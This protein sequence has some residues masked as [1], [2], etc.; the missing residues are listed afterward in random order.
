LAC[1][2]SSP[3]VVYRLAF[4]PYA[5]SSRNSVQ[6]TV[7]F[8]RSSCEREQPEKSVR[9]AIRLPPSK[10]EGGQ[11]A[12][13]ATSATPV[14]HQP[15]AKK[16]RRPSGSRGKR[17]LL[18]KTLSPSLSSVRPSETGTASSARARLRAPSQRRT[19]GQTRRF[20]SVSASSVSAHSC[21]PLPRI[22]LSVV[23]RKLV[24]MTT[25]PKLY[26]PDSPQ[27]GSHLGRDKLAALTTW[28][29]QKHK[30][31]PPR[32]ELIRSTVDH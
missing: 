8:Q 21:C 19:A 27:Q 2:R 11:P 30:P 5:I 18:G 25:K 28:T 20:A 1:R 3:G 12:S 10:R 29:Y 22:G 16:A 15:A 24:P 23:C 17:Q 6:T 13:R 9:D 4:F 26:H 32:S 7:A 31:G 14:P